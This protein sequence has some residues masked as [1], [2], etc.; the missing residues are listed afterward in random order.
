MH[1][2][3]TALR[4]TNDNFDSAGFEAGV[5]ALLSK[6]KEQL[7]EG[8]INKSRSL[9][10]MA[11]DEAD[12][13]TRHDLSGFTALQH[14]KRDLSQRYS[15]ACEAFHA[16]VEEYRGI[17]PAL[18]DRLETL[19]Q[20]IGETA[21]KNNAAMQALIAAHNDIGGGCATLIAAQEIGQ[22]FSD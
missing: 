3:H 6:P 14:D 15:D 12:F 5:E 4:K 20:Q 16:R 9:L 17:S 7:F 10:Q 11:R 19:Q 22:D 1:T 2:R 21:R 13:L 18:L 8:L